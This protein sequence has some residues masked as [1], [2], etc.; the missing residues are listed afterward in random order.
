MMLDPVVLS[1]LTTAVAFVGQEF[2]KGV[3]G[4]A[5]KATWNGIK[6]LFGWYTDPPLAEIPTKV[7]EGLSHSPEISEKLLELLKQDR[8][9]PAASL[10]QSVTVTGGKVVFAQKVDTLN[11]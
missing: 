2:A 10:V 6:H 3:S 5:G 1:S 7:A 9:G 8:L 4:E 11:M